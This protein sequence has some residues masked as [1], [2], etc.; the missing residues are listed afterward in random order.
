MN[1]ILNWVFIIV[2]SSAIF[3]CIIDYNIQYNAQKLIIPWLGVLTIILYFLIFGFGV[4]YTK[5]D[6]IC[7]TSNSNVAFYATTFPFI[8]IYILGMMLIQFFPGWLR[9]FSNTFGL[10][11]VQMCGYSETVNKYINEIKHNNSQ[12]KQTNSKDNSTIMEFIYND[13]DTLI[14]EFNYPNNINEKWTEFEFPLNQSSTENVKELK[15]DFLSYMLMKDT[16]A[17]H[18][19]VFLLASVSAL[20]TQNMLLSENCS[21]TVEK[22]SDFQDYIATQLKD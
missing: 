11:I 18:I 8:F 12:N 22:D 5:N 13:P 1:N 16:V 17:I 10:T 15:Q 9:S 6:F 7:G 3:K 21:K 4:E 14:N 19:W 2:I 20:V